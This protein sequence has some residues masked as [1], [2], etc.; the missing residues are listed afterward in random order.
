MTCNLL[1]QSHANKTGK[2]PSTAT[3]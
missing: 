3:V 1:Q 2:K